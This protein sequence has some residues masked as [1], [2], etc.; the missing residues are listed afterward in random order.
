MAR[1]SLLVVLLVGLGAARAPEAAAQRAPA[2]A[3]ADS[4]AFLVVA[5]AEGRPVH[6]AHLLLS[7]AGGRSALLVSGRD[8]L[9]ILTDVPAGRARI[10]VSHVGFRALDTTLVLTGRR[11]APPL[12]LELRPRPLS[13]PDVAVVARRTPNDRRRQGAGFEARRATGAGVFLTAEEIRRRG[14]RRFPDVFRLIP[15]M[16][17]TSSRLVES[18]ESTRQPGCPV[19][20]F[21]DGVRVHNGH[22]FIGSIPIESV[23]A[24]E[25]YRGISEIPAQYRPLDRT[26][27]AVLVWTRIT[28]H[29]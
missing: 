17:V 6:G 11:R 2:R 8:G 1:S 22:T 4:V 18:L 23:L 25:A 28:V 27:G 19:A 3:M 21:L 26:C 15:G 29:D 12:R 10:L 13:L 24:L 5:G 9:G 7:D 20:V 16:Q 14:I